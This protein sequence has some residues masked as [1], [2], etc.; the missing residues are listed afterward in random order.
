MSSSTNPTVPATTTSTE[1]KISLSSSSSLTPPNNHSTL[2]SIHP[3]FEGT[4]V[5]DYIFESR[6]GA[7]TKYALIPWYGTNAIVYRAH[8]TTFPS[9]SYAIKIIL[10]YDDHLNTQDVKDSANEVTKC[11]CWNPS[12]AFSVDVLLK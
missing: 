7:R 11:Y 10:N 9:Q 8:L 4:K 2:T 12:L 6:L 5:N 1:T 3:S